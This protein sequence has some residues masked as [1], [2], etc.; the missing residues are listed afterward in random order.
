MSPPEQSDRHAAGWT[1]A[2]LLRQPKT[3]VAQGKVKAG[4]PAGDLSSIQAIRVSFLKHSAARSASGV[5]SSSPPPPARRPPS[6]PHPPAPFSKTKDRV[7]VCEKSG[8][9]MVKIPACVWG[10][11]GVWGFFLGGGSEGIPFHSDLFSL[12]P[13]NNYFMSAV[14]SWSIDLHLI[15]LFPAHAEVPAAGT[16]FM[17]RDSHM[18]KMAKENAVRSMEPRAWDTLD[19]GAPIHPP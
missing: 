9:G 15:C 18:G 3:K 11:F 16:E 10:G 4:R 7:R 17:H 8:G 2:D 6:R 14:I 12:W 13:E 5:F 1:R 19:H